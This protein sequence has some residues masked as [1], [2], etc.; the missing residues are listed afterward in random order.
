[1]DPAANLVTIDY[2]KAGVKT[3]IPEASAS[4]I[5]IKNDTNALVGFADSYSRTAGSSVDASQAKNS[6]AIEITYGSTQHESFIN[7]NLSSTDYKRLLIVPMPD[8]S[9]VK[10]LFGYDT[11]TTEQAFYNGSWAESVL[12]A[13]RGYKPEVNQ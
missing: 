1:M 6:E 12:E 2:Y 9:T 10:L 8:R 4:F 3:N 11:Y 5:T 7:S 13:A